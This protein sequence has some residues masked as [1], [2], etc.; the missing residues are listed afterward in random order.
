MYIFVIKIVLFNLVQ[1]LRW[2]HGGFYV[3]RAHILPVFFQQRNE[4]VY[5]E[6]DVLHQLVGCHVNVPD[7]HRQA[8]H[9]QD[10]D[11]L[12]SKSTNKKS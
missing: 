10:K 9:L 3:K 8:Q 1:S 11:R 6:M 5:R 4:E 2:P 7:S 12:V